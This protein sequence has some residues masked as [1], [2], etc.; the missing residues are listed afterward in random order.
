MTISTLIFGL[1]AFTNNAW[2][3]FAVS[4]LARTLEGIADASI[5]CT[6][7]SII[8]REFPDKQERY[9]GYLNMSIGVGTFFGPL[10]GCLM[11]K[12]LNYPETFGVITLLIG[13]S[14]IV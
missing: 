9:L 1:A 3:F 7:P 8:C 5:T 2:A 10:L 12:Y 11:Y 6:M 14:A 13:G 4:A